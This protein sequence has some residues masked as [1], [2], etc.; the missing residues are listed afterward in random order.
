LDSSVELNKNMIIFFRSHCISETQICVAF[1]VPACDQNRPVYW[2]ISATFVNCNFSK[3]ERN[4][5]PIEYQN[6]N[7]KLQSIKK[8]AK[9]K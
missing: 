7:E 2:H 5:L 1:K 8:L 9:L 6:V 3:V 4:F